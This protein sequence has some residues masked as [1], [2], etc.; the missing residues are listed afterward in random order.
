MFIC[1]HFWL[2]Y[3]NVQCYIYMMDKMIMI[4]VHV[5]SYVAKI[6]WWKCYVLVII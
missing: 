6:Y 4:I 1:Y 2:D 5:S 3:I